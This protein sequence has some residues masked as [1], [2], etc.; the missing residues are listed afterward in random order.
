MSADSTEGLRN[1]MKRGRKGA[2]ALFVEDEVAGDRGGRST[3]P[4][5]R[6]FN[7]MQ[8]FKSFRGT[9]T[10]V[11]TFM[12]FLA[13]ER[14]TL[15]VRNLASNFADVYILIL[16]TCRAGG[17]T[18]GFFMATNQA[19][20]FLDVFSHVH[21]STLSF[22]LLYLIILL[23]KRTIYP[24]Y[25]VPSCSFVFLQSFSSVKR[26]TGSMMLRGFTLFI[27]S[28]GLIYISLSLCLS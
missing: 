27:N 3:G 20:I 2:R 17:S 19:Q 5:A 10:N 28:Y 7:V 9:L 26:I 15:V 24:R 25:Y 18:Y 22:S 12:M 23:V 4:A 21:I 14:Q 1:G 16:H 8:R 13:G 11:E 6:S